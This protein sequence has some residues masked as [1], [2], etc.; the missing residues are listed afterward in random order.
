ML[1][2][3]SLLLA[4]VL[5]AAPA[6]A[7]CGHG[8]VGEPHGEMETGGEAPCHG[9]PTAPPDDA[10]TPPCAMVCCAAEVRDPVTTAPAPATDA[11]PVVVAVAVEPPAPTR[12]V[13]PTAS[14]PPPGERRYAEV[15]RLL[16]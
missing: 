14:P 15:Q 11:V 8:S 5:A 10:G 16:I 7:A 2:T 6:A 13:V 12:D 4:L 3:V 9:E 1:R